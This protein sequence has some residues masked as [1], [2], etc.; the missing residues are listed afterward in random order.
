MSNI[1]EICLTALKENST[2]INPP[3]PKCLLIRLFIT[4][5]SVIRA[6]G[7]C[8]NSMLSLEGYSF[9]SGYILN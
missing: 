7:E 2:F 5:V 3:G 4:L 9:N 6:Q 1:F 8:H